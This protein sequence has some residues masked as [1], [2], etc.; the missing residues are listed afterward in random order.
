MS[1]TKI[2]VTIERYTKSNIVTITATVTK[3]ILSM[4]SSPARFMSATN[5]AGPVT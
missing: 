2:T 3:V 1:S 5:G 4:E